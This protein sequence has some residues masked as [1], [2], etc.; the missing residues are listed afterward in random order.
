M[1]TPLSLA[2]LLG[3][4]ML[5][6]MRADLIGPDSFTFTPVHVPGSTSTIALGINNSGQIVG[7][8]T[9]ASGTHGFLDTNNVFT[10]VPFLPT[11]INNV[12]Q[13]VGYSSD[14]VF[15][16]TNGVVTDIALP[17]FGRPAGDLV[18]V[19]RINDLGQIAGSYW[20]ADIRQPVRAFVYTNGALTFLPLVVGGDE[21]TIVPKGINNAGQILVTTNIGFGSG[22]AYLYQNGSYTRIDGQNSPAVSLNNTGEIVTTAGGGTG[23]IIYQNG[24]L[25]GAFS[26]AQLGLGVPTDVNDLGQILFNQTLG[27]PVAIP[28]PASLLLLGGG[29]AGLVCWRGRGRASGYKCTA[30]VTSR[31]AS[32]IQRVRSLTDRTAQRFRQGQCAGGAFQQ[33]FL[34]T[35]EPG[36]VMFCCS[37]LL[38]L[39][40]IRIRT[41][42]RWSGT[43]LSQPEQRGNALVLFFKEGNK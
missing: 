30:S 34:Y 28:E 13:I 27:T 20:Q 8:Y 3:L 37:G 33:Q 5:Q 19:A 10:T 17:N 4:G 22:Y 7:S 12:G 38:A 43:R 25:A 39:E 31:P 24:V 11:G 2:L 14:G 23:V 21:E 36:G 32:R 26:T 1:K 29:L 6:P 16:D 9:D 41:Q 35:P 42:Q 15:L 40:A 18:T